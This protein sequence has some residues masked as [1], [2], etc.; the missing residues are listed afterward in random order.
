[1]ASEMIRWV[2]EHRLR[3]RAA[4]WREPSDITRETKSNITPASIIGDCVMVTWSDRG[5]SC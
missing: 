4:V 1:M 5:N 2:A 3:S